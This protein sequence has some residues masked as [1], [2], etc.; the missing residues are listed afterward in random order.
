MP[1]AAGVLLAAGP[2]PSPSDAQGRSAPYVSG[3]GVARTA[4]GPA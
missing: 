1:S 2:S 3:P 4:E